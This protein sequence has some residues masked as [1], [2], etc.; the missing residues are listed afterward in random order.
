MGDPRPPVRPNG[1]HIGPKVTPDWW[2]FIRQVTIFILAIFLIIYSMITPGHDV[3]FLVT[4][5]ILI[6][7]IPAERMVQRGQEKRSQRS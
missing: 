2:D 5:L 3:P 7:I 1:S 6:G 4:A